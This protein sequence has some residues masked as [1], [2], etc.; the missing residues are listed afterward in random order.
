M[1]LFYFRLI[2]LHDCF[3]GVNFFISSHVESCFDLLQ[4]GVLG[5]TNNNTAQATRSDIMVLF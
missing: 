5:I 1:I 3:A 4:I 2:L